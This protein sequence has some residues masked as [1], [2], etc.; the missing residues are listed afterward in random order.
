LR[1]QLVSEFLFALTGFMVVF[2]VGAVFL[3]AS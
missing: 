3:A 2:E 1:V